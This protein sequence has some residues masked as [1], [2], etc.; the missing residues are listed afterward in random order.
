MAEDDIIGLEWEER[1]LGLRVLV[2]QYM[3][4]PG[5]EDR[6]EWV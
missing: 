6:S 4:M 2:P 1:P 5:Q 3:E